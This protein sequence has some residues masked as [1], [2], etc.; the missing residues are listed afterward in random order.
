MYDNLIQKVDLS[1]GVDGSKAG[2]NVH[3]KG[4]SEMNEI[5][6]EINQIME[7]SEGNENIQ[8][9]TME[10]QL[11]IATREI[12]IEENYFDPISSVEFSISLQI[13]ENGMDRSGSNLI[14][15]SLTKTNSAP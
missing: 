11:Q 7:V 15:K 12:A 5:Q 8:Q 10:D 13:A 14:T 9:L 1:G 3:E 4:Q 2:L 6:K